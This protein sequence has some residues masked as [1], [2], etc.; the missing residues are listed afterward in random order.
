MSGCADKA[1][2]L[3]QLSNKSALRL[4]SN[5]P[6]PIGAAQRIVKSTRNMR[7][8][9]GI[10]ILGPNDFA[11]G[12]VVARIELLLSSVNNLSIVIA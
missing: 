12:F 10:E 9:G 4:S 7:L 6:L 1:P 11:N 5:E 8:V 2:I 3:F